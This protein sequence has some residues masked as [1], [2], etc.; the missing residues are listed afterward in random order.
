MEGT[1][2]M[3][4]NFAL[5]LLKVLDAS[6][7]VKMSHS[8]TRFESVIRKELLTGGVFS[9]SWFVRFL[10]MHQHNTKNPSMGLFLYLLFSLHVTAEQYNIFLSVRLC[11]P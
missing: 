1:D 2:L 3:R 11:L 9:T 7:T 5:C 8:L 4:I 10:L 6:G